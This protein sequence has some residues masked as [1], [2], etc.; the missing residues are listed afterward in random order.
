MYELFNFKYF[1]VGNVRDDTSNE[2]E[3]SDL[4]PESQ[5]TVPA[6]EALSIRQMSS[7]SSDEASEEGTPRF[8]LLNYLRGSVRDR[9]IPVE[10]SNDEADRLKHPMSLERSCTDAAWLACFVACIFA[11]ST[12]SFAV[13]MP[14]QSESVPT[15]LAVHDS[16]KHTCGVEQMS[17]ETVAF[18]CKDDYGNLNFTDIICLESCPLNSTSHMCWSNASQTRVEVAG[19]AAR[20]AI[21]FILGWCRPVDNFLNGEC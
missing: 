4:R 7:S 13:R 6:N 5:R 8:H 11:L 17:H 10:K 9:S 15:L 21:P 12:L 16:L 19:Y 20:T 2:I 18:I 14:G 3:V 1:C